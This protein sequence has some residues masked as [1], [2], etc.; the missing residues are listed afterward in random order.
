[1]KNPSMLLAVLLA[2]LGW[3]LI[4]DTAAAQ[5]SGY[6]AYGAWR[7]RAST[8][9]GPHGARSR[10]RW[11]GGITP[12]GAAMVQNIFTD[13]NFLDL[14]GGFISG[15]SLEVEYV[16]HEELDEL[17]ALRAEYRAAYRKAEALE[18]SALR[19]ESD[20]DLKRI[21]DEHRKIIA[22]LRARTPG[23][24]PT[25]ATATP[26]GLETRTQRYMADARAIYEAR[27]DSNQIPEVRT[28][29]ERLERRYGE[30]QE[31]LRATNTAL[32]ALQDARGS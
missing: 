30:V 19:A 15:R 13:P 1:L 16:S 20:S 25:T 3:L 9:I 14:F 27:G 5:F 28:E 23:M 26:A 2:I 32:K 7:G 12:Q 22:E 18:R 21:L 29:G 17:R 10:V 4:S 31:A 6:P 8:V 24:A 11:G